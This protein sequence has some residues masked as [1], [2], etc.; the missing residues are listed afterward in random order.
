MRKNHVN[1]IGNHVCFAKIAPEGGEKIRSRKEAL[2]IFGFWWRRPLGGI[3]PDG[4]RRWPKKII[5][6]V[7]ESKEAIL[8]GQLK[9]EH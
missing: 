8:F 9:F 5:N 7:S 3:V 6:V 2:D 1:L 4:R